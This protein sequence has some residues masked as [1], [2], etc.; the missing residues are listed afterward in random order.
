MAVS[1]VKKTPTQ[2]EYGQGMS[3]ISYTERNKFIV[4]NDGMV[5]LYANYRAGAYLQISVSNSDGSGE[6][7]FNTFATGI[8][9]SIIPVPVFAG[10]KVWVEANNPQTSA[11]GTNYLTYIPYKDKISN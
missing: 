2:K 4:P 10:Q 11:G 7:L 5:E 3:I 1:I 8:S 6:R 9:N